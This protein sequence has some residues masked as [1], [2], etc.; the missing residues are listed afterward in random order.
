MPALLTPNH[1]SWHD[2]LVV[3]VKAAPHFVAKAEVAS[4]PILGY[5]GKQ[6]DTLFI[7]RGNRHAA[8]EIAEQMASRL[9]QRSIVVFPEGTTS[10]GESVQHFKRRLFEPA[11]KLSSPIQPIA[12]HY[13]SKDKKGRSLGFG[14]ESFVCHFWRTLGVE[15]IQVAVLFC[16]PILPAGESTVELAKEAQRRVE[17]AKK[18]L[19]KTNHFNLSA[20]PQ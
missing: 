6:A 3:G 20:F 8:A 18:Q 4:W 11:Q 2:V 5:L 17:H 10:E 12:L 15:K 16:Q 1:I 7:D 14:D 13:F 19:L 9:E